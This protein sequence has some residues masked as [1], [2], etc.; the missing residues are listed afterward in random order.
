MPSQVYYPIALHKQQA[1]SSLARS[2]N[3]MT[4]A[5]RLC[6][7]VLSLPMHTELSVEQLQYIVSQIKT[8][9]Q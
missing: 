1:F 7:E 8:F 9:F 2:G 3:E 4:N 5:E 6:G